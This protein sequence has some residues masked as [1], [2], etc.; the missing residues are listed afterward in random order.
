VKRVWLLCLIILC[1]GLRTQTTT[2]QSTANKP[3]AEFIGVYSEI[4]GTVLAASPTTYDDQGWPVVLPFQFEFNGTLHSEV[5]MTSNGY[6]VFP[7]NYAFF[8]YM[9][10]LNSQANGYSENVI[11]VWGD[12]LIGMGGATYSLSY[13]VSG[14]APNRVITFQWKNWMTYYNVGDQLNFQVKLYETSN[15]IEFVYGAITNPS[16]ATQSINVGLA[17]TYPSDIQNRVGPWLGS[18]AST[19]G[20]VHKSYSSTN[21]PP[22]GLTYRFGC[23]VPQGSVDVA[24]VDAQGNPAAYYTTPGMAYV[25]YMV[26]Y[27]PD[28]AYDVEITLSFHRIGDNS[29]VPV[30]TDY[31][32]AHKPLGI[33]HGTRAL[34]LNLPPAYYRVEAS[35]NVWNNCLMDE[36][37]MDQVSTLFIAAGTALCEVWPGD[38]NNDLLVN[39]SD[40]RDLNSYIQNANLSPLWLTGPAR[41]KIEAGSNPMAYYAWEVQ[42]S[43][44]W[45]T[46]EGCYMDADGNGVVDNL[47][48]LVIKV[49]WARAHGS[50]AP[51][52]GDSFAAATFDMDQNFPNP[53]NPSTTIQYSAPERSRVRL[54]VTDM[55]GREVAMLVDSIVEAGQYQARF[56]ASQISGGKYIARVE[57]TGIESGLTFSRA[58]GMSLSK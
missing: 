24:M 13:D 38:V 30:F 27:P 12:D 58:I 20:A 4:S 15:M 44:P 6:L 46:P 43:I 57:M 17:S 36:E 49:N 34:N 22:T 7:S 54:V 51:K 3:F 35:F 5:N 25:R 39:Y 45:N 11:S 2:A 19:D 41:F 55:L 40:R 50:I 31:F 10:P 56:D 47:D 29:G 18:S 53:F 14:V 48:Y 16:V 21:M 33:L 23:L 8:Y 1:S 28:Q 26:N 37:V 32:T 9:P 52:P 42:P